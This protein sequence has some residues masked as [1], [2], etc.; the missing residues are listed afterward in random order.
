MMALMTTGNLAKMPLRVPVSLHLSLKESARREG[1]SLN[2]YCLYLLARHSGAD[3]DLNREK[4][5]ALLRFLEE[6]RI[7]QREL[8]GHKKTSEEVKPQETAL[9]RWKRIYGKNRSRAH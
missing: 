1:V 7:L 6:A 5:E 3:P 8:R 2:Q 4:G 9:Q